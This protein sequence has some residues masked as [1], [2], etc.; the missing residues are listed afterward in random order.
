[1]GIVEQIKWFVNNPV[2]LT[3]VEI[4]PKKYGDK[5]KEIFNRIEA[6]LDEVLAGMAIGKI[7]LD[8]PT[9]L[10]RLQCVVDAI[11][12]TPEEQRGVIYA[13]MATRYLQIRSRDYTK[14]GKE[15]PGMVARNLI[16]G[17]L[18]KRN[19]EKAGIKAATTI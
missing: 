3:L 6:V 4:F 8:K 13:E 14:D 5:A 12:N 9:F 19:A 15:I 17:E 11:K 10:E 18:I 2:V 7:C 1:V 16:E